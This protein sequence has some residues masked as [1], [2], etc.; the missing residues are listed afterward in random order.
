MIRSPGSRNG[1]FEYGGVAFFGLGAVVSLLQFVPNSSFLRVD[2]EGLTIRTMWR[3]TLYR[4][5]DIEEFGVAG[6]FGGNR[7]VGLNFSASY[8]GGARKLR[9]FMRRLTGFE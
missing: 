9:A 7:L 5:T 1:F 3:T 2:P 4:W 8:S 6:S